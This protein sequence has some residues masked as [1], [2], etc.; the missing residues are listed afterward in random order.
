MNTHNSSKYICVRCSHKRSSHDL[1]LP[2]GDLIN[3]YCLRKHCKC[4]GFLD[5]KHLKELIK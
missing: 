5:A 2:E 1:A 3:Q 4:K